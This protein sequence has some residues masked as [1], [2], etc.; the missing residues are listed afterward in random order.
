M[1]FRVLL[2]LLLLLTTL[3]KESRVVVVD[4][5]EYLRLLGEASIN[6]TSKFYQL[7]TQRDQKQEDD[8]LSITSPSSRRKRS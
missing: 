1:I 6:D 8:L 3:D 4:T 7:S 2:L 5:T